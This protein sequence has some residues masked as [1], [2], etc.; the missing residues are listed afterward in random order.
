[1]NSV[2]KILILFTLVCLRF[3]GNSGTF[4]VSP[5]GDDLSPG[6]SNLPWRTIQKA[7]D[8]LNAGDTGIV[9]AGNYDQRVVTK[10]GGSSDSQRIILRGEGNPTMRGFSVKHPF[11]TLEGF[12]IARHS[13]SDRYVGFIE[14]TK[15]GDHLNLFNC[16]VRDGIHLIGTNLTFSGNTLS[17]PVGG[18]VASGFAP[19]QTFMVGRATNTISLQNTAT[20][21]ISAVTDHTLTINGTFVTE[22]PVPAY[23]SASYN[24]G[25]S[26]RAGAENCLIRS[27]VFSNLSYD[28]WSIDGA[29]HTLENNRLESCHGWDVMHFMGANHIFK[30]NYIGRSPWLVHQNSPDVF[31]N[32]STTRYAHILFTNN[33][34]E[35]F[36]G[37]LAAQ[38]IGSI[39]DMGPLKFTRNVFI[40]VGRYNGRYPNTTFENNTFLNVA[41]IWEDGAIAAE[42]ALTFD[43]NNTI[44]TTIRNNIFVGCGNASRDTTTN[45][46]GWYSVNPSLAGVVTTNNFVSGPAPTFARKANYVVENEN[47]NGGD[48]GFVNIGDPLGPDGIPFTQDDGLRL[49]ADSKLRDL[50]LGA[51]RSAEQR[52]AL[53]ILLQGELVSLSWPNSASNLMLQFSPSLSDNL[54]LNTTNADEFGASF[55]ATG[56]SGFFRLIESAP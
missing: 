11:V 25:L 45:S 36:A 1:M 19:G 37:V 21:V 56:H 31:E 52:Q 16:S 35:N 43:P 22:G 34:V 6:T 50:D 18:F 33:F 32:I 7:A 27:N 47:L 42:H 8:T 44:G 5:D 20:Y 48:P 30:G 55:P 26:I 53:E 15:D 17:S 10:R 28:T 9:R 14:V 41:A 13:S 29:G 39:L 46:T 38:K 51:Y 12:H 24:F 2:T 3:S 54:W 49:R 40:N 23:L 4:Y